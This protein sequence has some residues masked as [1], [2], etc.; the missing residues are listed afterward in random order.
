M[1]LTGL[2]AWISGCS[3][4]ILEGD[5]LICITNGGMTNVII[6]A[7][8]IF[9][10]VYYIKKKKGKTPMQKNFGSFCQ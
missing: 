7:V 1:S 3:G 4:Q 10:I 8:I 9:L 2:L 6:L 5:G